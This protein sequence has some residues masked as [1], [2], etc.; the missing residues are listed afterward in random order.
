MLLLIQWVGLIGGISVLHATR[1][2]AVVKT[3]TSSSETAEELAA[4]P[5]D[6]STKAED[7]LIATAGKSAVAVTTTQKSIELSTT[8]SEPNAATKIIA[9][10]TPDTPSTPAT[11]SQSSI[12]T[13][14]EPEVTPG[15]SN[16]TAPTKKPVTSRKSLTTY[17]SDYI[18]PTDYSVGATQ[19]KRKSAA[20][21]PSVVFS[22]RSTGCQAILS[23]GQGVASSLCSRT[24][25]ASKRAIANTNLTRSPSTMSTKSLKLGMLPSSGITSTR[26]NST[27]ASLSRSA[28]GSVSLSQ[29]PFR[30]GSPGAVWGNFASSFRNSSSIKIPKWFVPSNTRIIF[31]LAIPTA[32]T[33]AFGWRLHP[34]TGT[35]RFHSGTDLG[36]PMGTP[37]LAAYAGKVAI[38]DFMGGYGLAVVL[39]HNKGTQESLYGHLSEITVKPGAQVE[40]GDVIGLVGSTGNST[41]PHLHFEV[42]QSTPQGWVA[43]DPGQR[44]E[45]ALAQL[46][47]A[48][49]TAQAS[50]SR[51]GT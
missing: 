40:Q 50:S 43:V 8:T 36:A 35:W 25:Q 24:N 44:L 51:T 38:A 12:S 42:R 6:V 49:Q 32:I 7:L 22:E 19:P 15:S 46:V 39:D 26:G 13:T 3:A 1:G 31:P 47:R 4:Q 5:A 17:G 20:D 29:V 16:S 23:A 27:K 14:S 45:V 48:L 37:V 41:G 18:D 21:R 33:S 9:Q 28:T 10:T 34:I 11:S 30:S 2:W